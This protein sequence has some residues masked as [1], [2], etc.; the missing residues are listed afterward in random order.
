[1]ADERKLICVS[2]LR[3]ISFSGVLIIAVRVCLQAV[4][5]FPLDVKNIMRE[6]MYENSVGNPSVKHSSFWSQFEEY[7]LIFLFITRPQVKLIFMSES[8]CFL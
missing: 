7:T 1:M 6:E 3:H 5:S 4:V 2:A 8:R